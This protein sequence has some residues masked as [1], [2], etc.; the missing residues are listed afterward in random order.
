MNSLEMSGALNYM[1]FWINQF[2]INKVRLYNVVACGLL[3]Y[4]NNGDNRLLRNAGV[5]YRQMMSHARKQV[6]HVAQMGE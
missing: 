3:I 2:Q 4:L 1:T 5:F 6:G